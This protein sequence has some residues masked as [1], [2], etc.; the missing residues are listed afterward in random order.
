M[1]RRPS[2]AVALAL[3]LA[4]LAACGGRGPLARRATRLE[5]LVDPA[6]MRRNVETLARVPHRAGSPA[7][8][9]A[10]ETAAEFLRAAGLE[11]V[12]SEHT[13]GIPEPVEASLAVEGP[14]GRTFDLA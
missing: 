14:A 11:T 9:A 10:V 6:R 2:A 13:V 4:A 8:R 7:Q 1:T 12:I 5:T 3:A